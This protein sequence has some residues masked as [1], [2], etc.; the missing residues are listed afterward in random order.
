MSNYVINGKLKGFLCKDCSEPIFPAEVYLYLPWQEKSL[1]ANVVAG[2]KETFRQVNEKE[3]KQR[4]H[5]LLT[6]TETDAEGNFRIEVD[7]KHVGSA[8]DIDFVCKSVPRK[9]FGGIQ[10]EPEPPAP[11]QFHLTTIAPRW[12][13]Q[14][15]AGNPQETPEMFFKWEYVIPANWWCMIRGALFDAWLICG[16]L[17]NCKTGKPIARA[18]VQAWD[19][20]LL[21]DDFLG[22]AVTD[23]NGHFRIDYS[24]ADFRQNAFPLNLETDPAWPFF[25]KGPD[26]YFKATLGGVSLVDEGH[27]QRRNNVG[28]CL[29]V[30][31]CTEIQVA[32]NP[33]GSFPSAWTGIGKRFNISWDGHEDDFDAEGYAGHEK[34]A[35]CGNIRL[36]G[37]APA[38]SAAGNPV[39]YRFLV[40]HHTTPNGSASPAFTDYKTVGVTAGLFV[41]SVVAKLI[42]NTFPF[43]VYSVRSAQEDFDAEGWFD[44]NKAIERTRTLNGLGDLGNYSLIDEDTLI[45][46]NTAALTTA[47]DF[48]GIP[49][50][51]G[52]PFPADRKVAIEKIAIRFEIREVTDAA[53]PAYAIVAGSGKTLNSAIISNNRAFGR[54]DIDKLKATGSCAP[55]SGDIHALYTLYHPHLQSASI[56]LWNNSHTITRSLS[57][58]FLPLSGNTDASVQDNNSTTLKI[59]NPDNLSPCTYTLALDVSARLHNGDD[60][61][62]YLGR[63]SDTV[64][65]FFYG[66]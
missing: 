9:L 36:T 10:G 62:G 64:E 24:S 59:N 29:C 37:Q 16:H 54:L 4:E 43:P 34:Y 60:I 11:K 66:G 20:D 5:L 28:Y 23:A 35:L 26:I 7:P 65:T 22:S 2:T 61:T 21:S 63:N 55:I 3:A 38:R 32:D 25:S 50:D 39:Q 52:D 42:R 12:A 58:P 41:P 40:S 51:A 17:R 47:P 19:A 1:L 8:F 27:A 48:S 56:T 45:T 57:D 44:I 14:K 31:L 6:K 13:M 33:D 46:L 30:D 18:T 53:A 15:Q 49:L